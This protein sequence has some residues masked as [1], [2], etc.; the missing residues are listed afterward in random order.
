MGEGFWGQGLVIQWRRGFLNY[1]LGRLFV[2]EVVM[3]F[4]QV[5]AGLTD[6][7]VFAVVGGCL[8]WSDSSVE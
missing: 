2:F 5:H 4:D 6:N 7:V 3:D 1:R 8:H